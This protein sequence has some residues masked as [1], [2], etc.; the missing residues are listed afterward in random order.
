M[1]P[2][3]YV[4]LKVAQNAPRDV[5]IRIYKTM[6]GTVVTIKGKRYRSKGLVELMDGIKI[7][8]S[9]YAFPL[10]KMSKVMGELSE[11]GLDTFVEIIN[12]CTCE[13]D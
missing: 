10:E 5:K 1:K 8:G 2:S 3:G 6:N 4:L 12:M 11:R 9:L 7:S 13:C